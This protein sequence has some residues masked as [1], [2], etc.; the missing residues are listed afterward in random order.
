M[1]NSNTPALDWVFEKL[2]RGADMAAP[3]RPKSNNPPQS[4]PLVTVMPIVS[5]PRAPKK[6][7]EERQAELAGVKVGEL[8]LWKR[9]KTQG[10]KPEDL[11]PLLKS[12][13]RLIQN[14][15][16]LYKGKVEIPNAAI[17]FEHK[18]RVV[19]ALNTYDPSKGTNLATWITRTM[20]KADRFIKTNQNFARI[21]EPIANKIGKYNSA[22]AE[23]TDKLGHEPD[24][25]TLAE[26][27]GFS[28][29]EVKRLNKEQRKGLIS[30]GFGVDTTQGVFETNRLEEVKLLIF[31]LLSE[32]E[33]IVHEYTCGL[34][35]KPKVEKS[36]ELAKI[37]KWDVSK[38]S[39][40]KTSI[41]NKMAPHLE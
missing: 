18:Q 40:L 7:K 13:D 41:M 22:K 8:E 11:D 15:A 3:R 1:A 37:L 19:D 30:S 26:H 23:L 14:R 6:T 35:G 16:G 4:L 33:R 31:P 5:A 17:D 2:A 39:K 34:H 9:W 28:L 21:T 38:V 12:L 29:K 32:Q 10:R 20:M 25:I 36:G 24:A 27:T